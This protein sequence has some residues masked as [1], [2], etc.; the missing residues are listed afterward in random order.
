MERKLCIRK[1]RLRVSHPFS[2]IQT[3]KTFI[4]GW[5]AVAAPKQFLQW[6]AS[7]SDFLPRAF[8][9]TDYLPR[10]M[11]RAR[12][13]IR[14]FDFDVHLAAM[15]TQDDFCE[16]EEMVACWR[17]IS[18]YLHVDKKGGGAQQVPP[19]AGGK[20]PWYIHHHISENRNLFH[21]FEAEPATLFQLRPSHLD[22]NWDEPWHDTVT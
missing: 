15:S 13:P 21:C 10:V 22:P 3:M 4:S 9:I 17:K 5:P 8:I 14:C 2:G 20:P 16:S 6:R 7:I 1:T 12:T 18:G 11:S 19:H